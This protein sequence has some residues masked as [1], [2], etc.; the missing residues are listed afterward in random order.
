MM[1]LRTFADGWD[2]GTKIW[3]QT[4][5]RDLQHFCAETG[6]YISIQ[7]AVDEIDRRRYISDISGCDDIEELKQVLIERLET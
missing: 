1:D 4:A 6:D 5:A 7:E 3:A 2:E